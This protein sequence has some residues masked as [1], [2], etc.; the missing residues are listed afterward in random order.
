MSDDFAARPGKVHQLPARKPSA[1]DAAGITHW[2]YVMVEACEAFERGHQDTAI[3]ALA[4]ASKVALVERENVP[5]YIRDSL[6]RRVAGAGWEP[7][8]AA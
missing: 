5:V 7:R 4:E 8:G 6:L 3:L 1:W 2:E